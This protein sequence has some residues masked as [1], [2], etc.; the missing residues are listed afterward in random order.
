MKNG[1]LKVKSLSTDGVYRSRLGV[2]SIEDL[3]DGRRVGFWLES[4]VNPDTGTSNSTRFWHRRST[5]P[6]VR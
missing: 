4:A 1:D 5:A 3:G 6:Q 2:R